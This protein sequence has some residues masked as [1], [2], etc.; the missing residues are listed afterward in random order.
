M[1]RPVREPALRLL[2]PLVIWLGTSGSESRSARKSRLPS[3][4]LSL[5]PSSSL[6]Q[7]AVVIGVTRSVTCIPFQARSLGSVL[8]S[9]SSSSQP[10]EVPV[11]SAPPSPRRCLPSLVLK[12]AI[13]PLLVIPV[14][15]RT[16]LR[17][18]STPFRRLTSTFPQISGQRPSLSSPTTPSTPPGSR[19]RL[20]RSQWL[21]AKVE[22]AA[23]AVA[24][25]EVA[26]AVVDVV[27]AVPAVTEDTQSKIMLSEA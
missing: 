23:E 20:R 12:I 21:D 2:L 25:A 27:V 7:S 6:S 11:L 13:P 26:Q 15:L 3:R 22:I 8:P 1:G 14:P 24:E 4:A 19:N 10:P 5:P 18:L 17:P 9:V 16:S